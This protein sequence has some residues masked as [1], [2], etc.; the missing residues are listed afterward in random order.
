MRAGWRQ[1]PEESRTRFPPRA[2]AT[3]LAFKIRPKVRS[4]DAPPWRVN[5]GAVGD[6]SGLPVHVPRDDENPDRG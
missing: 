6:R 1:P 5:C 3:R 4:S 2:D